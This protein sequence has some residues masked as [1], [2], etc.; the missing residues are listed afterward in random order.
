MMYDAMER[1]QLALVKKFAAEEGV[2]E[3]E[4]IQLAVHVLLQKAHGLG[5]DLHTGPPPI[6]GAPLRHFTWYGQ[7]S[8]QHA[9]EA[10]P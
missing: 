10:A 1:Q 8:E 2:S 3:I 4:A 6:G 7:A 9:G 5:Y